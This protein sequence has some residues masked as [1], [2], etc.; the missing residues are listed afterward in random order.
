MTGPTFTNAV[1]AKC[2]EIWERE[3]E[4]PFVRGLGDGTLP[5][6]HFRFYLEQDYLF[7]IEYC[8]VFALASAKARALATINLF[9]GLLGDTLK[10]EMQMHRD[11]CKRLGI[12]ESV[13][14]SASNTAGSRLIGATC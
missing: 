12:A 6:D 7:L 8:R 9:A 4:H 5:A 3:L 14:E 10:V 11:Y 13:L 2:A 1:R